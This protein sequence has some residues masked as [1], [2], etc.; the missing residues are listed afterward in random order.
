[1]DPA[2]VFAQYSPLFT[3]GLLSGRNSP[4]ERSPCSSRAPSPPA[5]AR[6]H[7]QQ[8]SLPLTVSTVSFHPAVRASDTLDASAML[9]TLVPHRAYDDDDFEPGRSF[10][11]LDLAETSSQAVR[12]MSLRRKD[13]LT[14]RTSGH[15]APTSPAAASPA[16]PHARAPLRR[17]SRDTLL[18]APKPAPSTRPPAPPRHL[19]FNAL[20]CPSSSSSSCSLSAPSLSHAPRTHPALRLHPLTHRAARS[21]PSLPLPTLATSPILSPGL[22][23][24]LYSPIDP[25]PASAPASAPAFVSTRADSRPP[26]STPPLSAAPLHARPSVR[27]VASLATRLRNRSA[28]LAVLEGRTAPPRWGNF[29]CMTDEEDEEPAEGPAEGGQGQGKEQD[30]RLLEVLSEEEDVVLPEHALQPKCREAA[31]AGA[32]RRSRRGTIESILGP[33]ANFIE[34]RDEEW[35]WR[36][37]I[38]IGS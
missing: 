30:E 34:F 5:R 13:T 23:H 38:E 1:M 16:L 12:S 29:M 37:F 35:S 33:L 26:L 2:A 9:L 14:S 28:A 8:D 19:P 10:L 4:D 21:A 36:S 11:S 3:S 31:G 6:R 24:L 18:P 32:R 15:S 22:S 25:T 17:T 7:R 20:A 27:S